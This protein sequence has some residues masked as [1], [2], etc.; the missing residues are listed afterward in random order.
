MTTPTPC[1]ISDLRRGGITFILPAV[2]AGPDHKPSDKYI[3]LFLKNYREQGIRN[4][5][6][7]TTAEIRDKLVAASVQETF[8]VDDDPKVRF[9]RLIS[10]CQRVTPFIHESVVILDKESVDIGEN[11]TIYP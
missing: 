7:V 11:T 10:E 1:S 3:E 2:L 5:T 4:L 9:A 6:I 8:V